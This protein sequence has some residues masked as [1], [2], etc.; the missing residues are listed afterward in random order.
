MF[1]KDALHRAF[2]TATVLAALALPVA[3]SADTNDDA[4]RIGSPTIHGV[5]TSIH[6]PDGRWICDERSTTKPSAV[7]YH[8]HL[9]G[10]CRMLPVTIADITKV[11]FVSRAP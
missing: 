10:E 5:I 7:K 2:G 4:M 3:V 1:P 11:N 6:G 9:K 8:L